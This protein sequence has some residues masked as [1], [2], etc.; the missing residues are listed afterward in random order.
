MKKVILFNF[1]SLSLIFFLAEIF[2][3]K[4]IIDNLDCRY[5]L[6][7]ARYDI[8]HNEFGY[9]YK[10]SYTKDEYGFRGN[11]SSIS[12]V[13]FLVIGGSTTDQR[14]LSNEDTWIYKTNYLLN[15]LSKY[16][17]HFANSGIDGQ[18]TI[19]HIWNFQNWYNKIPELKP[20][21]I[22]FYIGLN[23]FLPRLHN[24]KFDN[25]R[26][27]FMD[28]IYSEIKNKSFFYNMFKIIV[29][30]FYSY[31]YNYLK[32]Y[33]ETE[34]LI[35]NIEPK[36][37]TNFW[38][39]YEKYLN[40]EFEERINK[41]INLSVAIN[42][43]PIFITQKSARWKIIN[44]KIF[45]I[46][47]NIKGNFFNSTIELNY[48][49]IGMAE[50]KISNKILNICSENKLECFDGLKYIKINENNTYDYFHVDVNG[51]NEI[52]NKISK[53]IWEKIIN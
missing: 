29:G 26:S 30:Y 46:E 39:K 28:I 35:F 49:D 40:N 53:F 43:V 52:A 42:A 4:W 25:K 8:I 10:F 20:K 34:E 24:R 31:K 12:N 6:C 17:Y 2:F 32:N 19:G 22:I 44:G 7:D 47:G 11:Y 41:L 3:G 48:A 14:L 27:E 16:Q 50:M 13:D 5:I 1:V 33:N 21:F 36:I 38:N 15:Q 9:N 51:S 18:S 37:N 45:A 23:D